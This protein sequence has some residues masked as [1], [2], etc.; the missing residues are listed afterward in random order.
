MK[1]PRRNQRQEERKKRQRRK[2]EEEPENPTR[3]RV[4]QFHDIIFNIGK[5]PQ[6][7][8]ADPESLSSAALPRG[9]RVDPNPDDVAAYHKD[10]GYLE[11]IRDAYAKAVSSE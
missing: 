5:K 9:N 1:L 4:P 2:G 8:K 11:R 10:G 6:G 7:E 3:T